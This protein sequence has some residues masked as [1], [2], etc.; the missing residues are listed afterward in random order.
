MSAAYTAC[1]AD[2]EGVTLKLT[3]IEP[4]RMLSTLI[5][6][7]VNWLRDTFNRSFSA[8]R[9]IECI[10]PG[11]RSEGFRPP[12]EKNPRVVVSNSTLLSVG[13]GVVVVATVVVV[14]SAVEETVVVVEAVVVVVEAVVVVVEAVV[15]VV[16]TVEVVVETVAVEETVAVAVEAVEVVVEAVEAGVVSTASP[17]PSAVVLPG[18]VR[19][20]SPLPLSSVLG[21]AVVDGAGARRH[22]CLTAPMLGIVV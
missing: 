19:R 21:S 5:M 7:G 16:E 17:L 12:N 18:V 9:I 6:P 11:C 13:Y 22:S 8:R 20:S 14:D 4:L 10:S 1:D 2:D 3:K 15:V